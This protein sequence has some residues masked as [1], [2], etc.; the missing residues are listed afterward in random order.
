M[1]LLT[2]SPLAVRWPPEH[3]WEA[4][5]GSPDPR[6]PTDTCRHAPSLAHSSQC[7]AFH[8]RGNPLRWHRYYPHFTGEKTQAP[9]VK[10]L[11]KVTWLVSGA[12]LQAGCLAP[13][14]SPC[15]TAL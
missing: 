9:E 10:G 14:P 2:E 11:P 4:W 3:C 12:G 15:T 13:E 1:L 8:P 6:C 7:F 5:R